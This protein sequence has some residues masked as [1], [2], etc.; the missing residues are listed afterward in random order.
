[1]LEE[2][3]L[4]DV[5]VDVVVVVDAIQDVHAQLEVEDLDVIDDPNENEVEKVHV[6]DQAPDVHVNGEVPSCI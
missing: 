1:M 6:D 2:D 3:V 4:N 5:T